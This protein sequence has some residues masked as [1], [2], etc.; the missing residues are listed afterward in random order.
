MRQD[1]LMKKNSIFGALRVNLKVLFSYKVNS[2]YAV[3]LRQRPFVEPS[4]CLL[5]GG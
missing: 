5:P 3:N 1:E 4:G 2:R